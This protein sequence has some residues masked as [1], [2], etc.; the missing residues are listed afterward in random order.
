MGKKTKRQEKEEVEEVAREG[1]EE[2]NENR[3]VKKSRIPT[4]EKGILG[5]IEDKAE[6]EGSDRNDSLESDV[7]EEKRSIQDADSLATYK[8]KMEKINPTRA[9][10]ARR[11]NQRK[12][13]TFVKVT[14]E[15]PSI[16]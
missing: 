12:M 7:N 15:V 1:E 8:K 2:P 5:D 11:D 10:R 14:Q 6:T 13:Q 4:K 9:E 16:L 3:K